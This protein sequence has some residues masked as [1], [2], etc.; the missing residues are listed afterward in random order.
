M[1][2]QV[3]GEKS[4]RDTPSEVLTVHLDFGMGGI[5][6]SS[7]ISI[8]N[9]IGHLFQG[10]LSPLLHSE[11]RYGYESLGSDIKAF[12]EAEMALFQ[13]ALLD[14]AP[15][16]PYYTSSM[17]GFVLLDIEHGSFKK[18]VRIAL[19]AIVLPIIPQVAGDALSRGILDHP[20]PISSSVVVPTEKSL[21]EFVS[22]LGT[23]QNDI[24]EKRDALNT[25]RSLLSLYSEIATIPNGKV[26]VSVLLKGQVTVTFELTSEQARHDLPLL[27]RRIV[28][29]TN[30]R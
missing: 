17:P 14:N 23:I 5:V 4:L 21:Q 20:P 11:N 28:M 18:Y 22:Y 10:W 6:D 19:M 1:T 9:S 15:P 26:T 8:E 24:E 12:R 3:L 29:H 25:Y 27:V 2:I 7:R 30:K 16:F 13:L